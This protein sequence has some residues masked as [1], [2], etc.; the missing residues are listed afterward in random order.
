[1]RSRHRR[2][3]LIF[4]VAQL[5]L[6]LRGAQFDVSDCVAISAGCCATWKT[7]SSLQSEG[8]LVFASGTMKFIG[9]DAAA[10]TGKTIAGVFRPRPC[11]G[12]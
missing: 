6:Q 4:R 12:R 5:G 3:F 8:R 10:L 1:M 11:W 9:L 7:R 2:P